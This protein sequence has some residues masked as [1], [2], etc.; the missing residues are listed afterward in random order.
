MPASK[1]PSPR[2]RRGGPRPGKD[3]ALTRE[4]IFRAAAEA[5]SRHGF[6]G[7]TVDDIARA[8]AVNKAMIYYHFTDKLGLYRE[9]VREML[10]AAQARVVAIAESTEPAETKIARWVEVFVALSEERPYMPPLMLRELA[11][12]APHLDPETLGLIG[13]L[14]GA[15][16]RILADGQASGAFREVNPMLAYITLLAPLMFNAARERAAA[17]RHDHDWPMFAVIPHAD[18]IRHMQQVALRMLQHD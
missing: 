12:G 6:S 5:F 10:R 2:A 3:P 1:S 8:A 18:V 14:L 4:A 11:E 17:A 15:F 16:K 9:I 7:V 13:A